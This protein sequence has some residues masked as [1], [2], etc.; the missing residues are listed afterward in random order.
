MPYRELLKELIQE[1]SIIISDVPITF[2]SGETGTVY[3]D[4][5]NTTLTAKGQFFI[6]QVVYRI[7][8]QALSKPKAVGGLTLGA[9]AIATA[10]AYCSFSLGDPIDAFIIR[11]EP[12]KHGTLAFIE[13]KINAGDPVILVDDVLTTGKS[14]IEAIKK[15][16]D[17]KLNILAII[18]LIDREEFDG[19][20]K[21]KQYHHPVYSIFKM[22]ELLTKETK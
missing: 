17:A 3:F 2:T 16:E 11:K 6:G 12:K 4:L 8:N 5:K 7:I 21:V 10:V 19:L 15:A 13:G 22:K 9:D 20:E 18:I 14:I 1:N